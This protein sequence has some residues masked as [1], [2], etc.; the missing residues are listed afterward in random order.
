MEADGT[1]MRRALL[2]AARA[3]SGT[4][5]NPMVGAVVVR[6]GKVVGEG[7]HRRAGGPHAEVIALKRAGARARGATLYVTLEPCAH[8]GRTPPCVEA[9]AQAGVRRVVAAMTD[10]NP[11][12]RGRGLRRLKASG[13]RASTGLMEKE[14]RALNRP[15]VTRMTRGRPFVTVKMAQSLDGKIATASG[16]SRWI[17]GPKARAWV[18]RLRA[19]SDAV[20]V[21]VGTVLKD[22]PLLTARLRGVKREPARVV[23]DS[24]LRTPVGARLFNAPAPVLIATTRGASRERERRLRERGAE[25]ERFPSEKGRVSLKAVLRWLA[26]REVTRV[27]I[28]GGGEVAAAA[29]EAGVAD[30]VCWIIA[31]KIIGGRKAPT[32]VEGTGAR[33]LRA[34]IPLKNFQVRRLGEDLLVTGDVG[35]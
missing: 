22:D 20:L 16:E 12:N 18:H 21:G 4:Y 9:V 10:P 31:P 3:G 29:F 23:L 5:P 14:A 7:F 15:F 19:E 33:F 30:R 6:A 27:L 11:L 25:V 34:A 32:S 2:L 28:E 35:R 8:T 13:I 17:S 24:R 1:H 26:R